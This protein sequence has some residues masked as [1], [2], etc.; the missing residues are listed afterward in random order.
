[1]TSS[2]TLLNYEVAL[3]MKW[4]TQA[5]QNQGLNY[6]AACEFTKILLNFKNIQEKK[7]PDQPLF[8]QND[9][10]GNFLKLEKY[11]F[12]LQNVYA[13]EARTRIDAIRESYGK[14][15]DI[16]EVIEQRIVNDIQI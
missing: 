9:K 2:N 6:G 5:L 7:W 4:F 3:E 10:E 11:F 13:I 12:K 14:D 15:G 16:P 8:R 1:M